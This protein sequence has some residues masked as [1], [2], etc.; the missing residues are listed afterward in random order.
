MSKTNHN[1]ICRRCGETNAADARV[2]TS[3]G[4]PLVR[5]ARAKVPLC[6]VVANA[7]SADA[8]GWYRALHRPAV[9]NG[10]ISLICAALL[11]L[12]FAPFISVSSRTPAGGS[13]SASFSPA[14]ILEYAISSASSHDEIS[15]TKTSEYKEQGLQGYI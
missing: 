2:C 12:L 10:I 14:E 9:Y 13:Y 7:A 4:E 15:I 6:P 11:L 3:C 5:D 8:P 1:R